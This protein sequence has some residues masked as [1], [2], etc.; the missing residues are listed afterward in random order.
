MGREQLWGEKDQCAFKKNEE[1]F[2]EKLKRDRSKESIQHCTKCLY[3]ARQYF[4]NENLIL[5]S[6]RGFLLRDFNNIQSPLH[7]FTMNNTAKLVLS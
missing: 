5:G 1:S 7:S 3:N 2:R 6:K 4:V